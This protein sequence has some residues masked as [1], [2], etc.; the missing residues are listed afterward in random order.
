MC[1]CV[2]AHRTN[3]ERR[4]G[5]CRR[6]QKHRE[7]DACV[8]S[9]RVISLIISVD[10]DVAPFVIPGR[11]SRAFVASVVAVSSSRGV[12]GIDERR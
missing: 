3:P 8:N 5:N 7:V 1:R 2:L 6:G 4:G 12:R 11:E 10:G 9:W